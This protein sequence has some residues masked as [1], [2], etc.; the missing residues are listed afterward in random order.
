MKKEIVDQS[1]HFLAGFVA[2]FLISMWINMFAA[3]L[4]VMVFAVCREIYQRVSTGRLW[5]QCYWGCKLDLLFW[6]LGIAVAVGIKE[7]GVI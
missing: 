4:I 3:G 7:I 5:Y 6:A 2:T 1:A